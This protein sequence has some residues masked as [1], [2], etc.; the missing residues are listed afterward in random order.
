MRFRH[1]QRYD[2]APGAVHAML[3][4][5]SFR[6]KVSLAQRA[7]DATVSV[8]RNGEAV[9]VVVD[10]SRPSTG[11]PGF[12]RKIVGDEI[13]IVQRE[14]WTGSSA[15]ELDVSI[16]GKPAQLNGTI[17]VVAEGT[18][19]SETVEGELRVNVPL[20]GAKIEGLVSGFLSEAL[21]VEQR[22]GRAWLAGDR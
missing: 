19:T 11:I 7:T 1:E 6:E 3:T 16:P 15:A 10:Q 2:A 9:T 5:P 17:K 4:D 20:V 13:R 14:E 12:A 8:E 22:V 18:G 21:A